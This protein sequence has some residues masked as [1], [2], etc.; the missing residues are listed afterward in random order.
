MQPR[1]EKVLSVL[2]TGVAITIGGIL[3]RREFFP[4]TTVIAPNAPSG[5]FP[6]WRSM[7]PAGR[8]SGSNKAPIAIVEFSEMECPF[9]RRFHLALAKLR[10]QYPDKIAHTFIHFP[11]PIHANAPGAAK[12]AECANEQGKFEAMIETVFER[13]SELGVQDWGWFAKKA[14]VQD[15][16]RFQ[17]CVERPDAPPIIA[18]GTEL[19]KRMQVAG[20]PTVFFN[21]WRVNGALPDTQL[22]RVV[23][24]LLARRKP[25]KKFPESALDASAP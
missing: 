9:C 25:F 6:D 4:P 10:T 20:T 15:Y 1:L 7:V 2:L 11:L 24:D 16:G 22:T 18:A 14:G 12:A 19:G 21:G 17:A 3:V 5:Y 8:T 13:Q 23:E